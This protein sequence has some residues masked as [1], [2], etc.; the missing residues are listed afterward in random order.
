MLLDSFK[1]NVARFLFFLEHGIKDLLLDL[2][3]NFQL[4]LQLREQL[5][6]S[7]EGVF[8]RRFKLLENGGNP[9][10]VFFE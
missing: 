5:L 6:A 7:F 10:V 2:R 4:I 9:G 3:V 1:G 8:G